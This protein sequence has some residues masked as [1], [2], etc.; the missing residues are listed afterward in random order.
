M[1]HMSS[2]S[3]VA[4]L[5]TAIHLLLTYV[6]DIGDVINSDDSLQISIGKNA[7]RTNTT[8]TMYT[9]MTLT[10]KLHRPNIP[11]LFTARCYA[12]AVLAMGLVR[13]YSR[14]CVQSKANMSQLTVIYRTDGTNN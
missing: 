6:K 7:D 1:W 10:H 2:R 5:R 4:I 9:L 13:L 8:Y 12:C 11:R 14:L 3:G